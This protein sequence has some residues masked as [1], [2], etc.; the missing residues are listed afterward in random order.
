MVVISEAETSANFVP[1]RIGTFV[2]G[3]QG[4]GRVL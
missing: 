4:A 2:T 3:I 1:E